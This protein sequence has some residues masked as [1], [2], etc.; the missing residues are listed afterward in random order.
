MEQVPAEAVSEIGKESAEKA[1]PV[2]K[3]ILIELKEGGEYTVHAKAGDM[4][5]SI[6]EQKVI[7]R[8]VLDHIQDRVMATMIQVCVQKMLEQQVKPD[9]FRKKSIK[10][11]LLGK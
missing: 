11:F 5:M 4:A 1:N 9:G 8:D 3:S 2:V 6:N 10:D 7:L